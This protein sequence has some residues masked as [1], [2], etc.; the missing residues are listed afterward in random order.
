MN[1]ILIVKNQQSE[2]NKDFQNQIIS[3]YLNYDDIM[4]IRQSFGFFITSSPCQ[5][6]L[7][8][9]IL[10]KI[11]Q[12]IHS[13]EKDFQQQLLEI[14]LIALFKLEKNIE[15]QDSKIQ[16]DSVCESIN[17]K[18]EKDSLKQEIK[19]SDWVDNSDF[20]LQKQKQSE[21]QSQILATNENNYRGLQNLGNTCYMNSYT[22]ALFMTKEFRFRLLQIQLL[23]IHKNTQEIQANKQEEN[24][25]NQNKKENDQEQEQTNSHQNDNNKIQVENQN[26]LKDNYNNINTNDKDK[27]IMNIEQNNK[28][29]EAKNTQQQQI[30]Q[31]NQQ[32][33]IME[34]QRNFTTVFQL[35]KLFTLLYQS[36]RPYINPQNFKASLPDLFKFSYAQHDSSE[37]GRMFLE[38]LEQSLKFSDHKNL[39]HDY[40]IGE[41]NN[42]LICQECKNQKIRKEK[43]M[44]ISLVFD[45]IVQQT[46]KEKIINSEQVSINQLLQNTFKDEEFKDD[47]KYYCDNCDKLSLNTIKHIKIDYLPNYVVMT[48]NRFQFDRNLKKKIK[49][50]Q[51]VNIQE[52]IN[53]KSY[54]DQQANQ[55]HQQENYLENQKQLQHNNSNKKERDEEQ[56][57][58]NNQESNE[59][60]HMDLEEN[61]YQQQK[62][63]LQQIQKET[64]QNQP[65]MDSDNNFEYQL[66][67][68]VIHRGKSPDSGHYYCLARENSSDESQWIIFDDSQISKQKNFTEVHNLIESKS[69]YDTPYLLFYQKKQIAQKFDDAEKNFEIKL[70]STLLSV[71]QRDNDL[72]MNEIQNASKLMSSIK[73]LKFQNYQ[74][75]QYNMNYNRG[76]DDSDDEDGGNNYGQDQFQNYNRDAKSLK[77][78][79]SVQSLWSGYGE[80][81]KCDLKQP[82]KN[83]IYNEK[84]D[85]V[86]CK[87]VAPPYIKNDQDVGHIR[88]LQSYQIEMN[89]YQ[90]F[91]KLTQNFDCKIPVLINA[92]K[93]N[94]QEKQQWYFILQDLDALGYDQRLGLLEPND[95][96]IEAVI[97]WLANF[98]ICYL[99]KSPKDLWKIGTYWHLNTRLEEL[100]KI[101][102]REIV[103]YAPKIDQKLNSAQFQTFVHGDAKIANFCFDKT[104]SK[105]AAVDFQYVGGGL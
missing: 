28:Q 52:M 20:Y 43:F 62:C 97:K 79:Q 25:K 74:I 39:L 40:F 4:Q 82:D 11:L 34:K 10:E 31:K 36:K 30:N 71:L 105:V 66:Y 85:T 7:Y 51:K 99:K 88:K 59:K 75:P 42:I 29:I 41:Y 70:S 14:C 53:L 58:Q 23:D 48:V 54:V 9:N 16:I 37:F 104:H 60:Q 35:Q 91:S 47:N 6:Q 18:Y 80:V 61:Q 67:A 76:K 64:N 13:Y 65:N 100:K 103:E 46:E 77:N 22:Q 38:Q 57:Y 89:Y 86:V 101:K 2:Q 95:P 45:D 87:R 49:I 90:Y 33:Q 96:G 8:Q 84:Q 78:Q 15:V 81:V 27:N 21:V 44:D 55:K 50:M 93:S 72:Y 63:Q 26:Q 32:L 102:N 73:S 19:E 1:W 92:Y 69:E 56:I 3:Q 12:K 5:I 83:L 68:I 24:L 94:E 17:F 98:H